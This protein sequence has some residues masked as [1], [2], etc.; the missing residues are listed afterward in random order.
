MMSAIPLWSLLKVRGVTEAH[1]LKA[2]R[3]ALST[4]A[5]FMSGVKFSILDH[6][7]RI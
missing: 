6:G 2:C 5:F 7:E 1:T 3:M 4:S